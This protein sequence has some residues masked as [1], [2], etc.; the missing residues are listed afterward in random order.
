MSLINSNCPPFKWL[1]TFEPDGMLESIPFQLPSAASEFQL[2]ETLGHA[3]IIHSAKVSPKQNQA[4]RNW[5]DG[6][7]GQ[8]EKD[9]WSD[10]LEFLFWSNE[11]IP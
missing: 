5:I 6:F 8:E 9:S 3:L 4:D 7:L 1:P 11:K 2:R 10:V